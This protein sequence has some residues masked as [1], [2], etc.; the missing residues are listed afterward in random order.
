MEL[1]FVY[2]AK[3]GLF[4]KAIDF[5]HKIVS[6]QT[7]ECSLCSITYG[8]FTVHKKWTDFIVSLKIPVKF[9]YKN[10][11]EALYPYISTIY[12]VVYLAR[13]ENLMQIAT[14][15]EIGKVNKD[16]NLSELIDLIKLKMLSYSTV[17]SKEII[18]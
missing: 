11:F 8:N 5:A 18:N 6:Q 7:Y 17:E 14:A 2:N 13:E 15:S 9:L 4:N 10:E 3:S 16:R 12:P 1:I